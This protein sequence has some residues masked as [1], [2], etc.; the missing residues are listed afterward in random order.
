MNQILALLTSL[1]KNIAVP[2]GAYFAGKTSKEL[3]ICK[4]ENKKLKELLTV[5]DRLV[6]TSEVYDENA[7]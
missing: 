2:L 4:K 5:H 6:Q 1:V 3:D 7:W